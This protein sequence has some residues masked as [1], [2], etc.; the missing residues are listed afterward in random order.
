MLLATPSVTGVGVPIVPVQLTATV[1][2]A[3]PS[4]KV[5][6]AGLREKVTLVGGRDLLNVNVA[7]VAGTST[8]AMQLPVVVL[9]LDKPPKE[10]VYEFAVAETDGDTVNVAIGIPVGVAGGAVSVFAP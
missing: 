9:T 10:I 5:S 3:P 2:A 8:A 7:V 4:A 1:C 6:D